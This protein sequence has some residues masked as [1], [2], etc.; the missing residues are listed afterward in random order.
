VTTTRGPGLAVALLGPPCLY[1][2]NLSASYA[3]VPWVCASG[4]LA[5]LDALAAVTA[6]PILL[7]LAWT[8]QIRRAFADGA[9][10]VPR[11]RFLVWM[12]LGSSAIFLL[13]TL[14][15]WSTQRIVPACAA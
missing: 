12:A 4:H 14:V 5:V 1:L 10:I 2:A 8:W 13:A 6:L 11:D 9:T 15:Q 7:G 3:L